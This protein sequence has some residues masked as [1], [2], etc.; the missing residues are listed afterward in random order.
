MTVQVAGLPVWGPSD[1]IGAARTIIRRADSAV[2]AV[3]ALPGRITTLLGEIEALVARIADLVARSDGV[4]RQAGA[5]TAGAAGV[6]GHADAVVDRAERVVTQAG[7]TSSAARDLLTTYAPIA[8]QAAPLARRFVEE[9]SADELRAAIRLVD[10]LP[11]LAQHLETDIMPVLGSLDRVGPN[12]HDLLD[13]LKDVRQ[14]VHG[15]PGI[16]YLQRRGERE[17]A[18]TAS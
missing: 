10:Q 11:A 3:T 17:E 12:V 2:G 15:I 1:V 18:R 14:A 13:V 5:I 8:D 7:S 4:V 16:R 6:V 9:F